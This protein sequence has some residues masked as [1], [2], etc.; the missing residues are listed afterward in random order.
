MNMR[1][2]PVLGAVAIAAIAAA[3]PLQAHAEF[4]ER[5]V[6]MIVGF[7]AGGGT[8]TVARLVAE[9]LSEAW[10][11]SV[12]VENRPGADGSIAA[13]AVATAPADGY[14]VAV[15]SNAHTITPSMGKVPY[16]A[17]ES[18]EPITLMASQPN[19][20]LLHPSIEANSVAELIALAKAKPGDLT[21]ASSGEGTS[22]YLAMQ[23]FMQMTGTEMVHVP[24]KGSAPAVLGIVSGEVQLMFGAVSTTMPHVKDGALKALAVTTPARLAG[25]PDIPT[26]AE[27]APELAGFQA[28]SW[29]GV[30][31]PKGTPPEVV[32]KL[33]EG[34]VQA[35]TAPE[36]KARLEEMGVDVV[37]NSPEE[38]KQA[39]ADDIAT[40]AEVIANIKK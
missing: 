39:I 24:Y 4:P 2:A 5:P 37:A 12:V 14:T 29:Y 32:K 13:A 40:W 31:A 35:L 23:R 28:A 18:F 30:L 33:N 20:L 8:D 21:F 10:G 16:D 6:Q 22:P 17:I 9:K 15:V 1:C 27:S 7:S 11:Q 34:M 3:I 25:L 36:M 19:L 38:F 26:V